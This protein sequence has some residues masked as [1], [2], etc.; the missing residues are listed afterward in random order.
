MYKDDD[1][2]MEVILGESFMEK[3]S[4]AVIMIMSGSVT[5]FVLTIVYHIWRY[6]FVCN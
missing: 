2:E 3:A 5:L 4:F 1:Y 6:G